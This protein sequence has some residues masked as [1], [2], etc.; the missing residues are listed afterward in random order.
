MSC[1]ELLLVPDLVPKEELFYLEEE[2][3][4]NCVFFLDSVFPLCLYTVGGGG[5]MQ[6]V[7]ARH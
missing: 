2:I 3:K 4:G 1:G 5:S 6:P 7:T